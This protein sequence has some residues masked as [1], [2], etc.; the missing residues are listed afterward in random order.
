MVYVDLPLNTNLKPGAYL[1]GTIII[2]ST[3]RS[4]IIPSSALVNRDGYN[5]VMRVDTHNIVIQ[6]KI[7][8]ADYHDYNVDY[9][10][11]KA[12]L[13]LNDKIVTTGAG[14]LNDGDLVQIVSGTKKP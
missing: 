5:Y 3:E 9:V 4:M 7:A 8:L 2:D 14:F 11:V 13:N 12:G 1:A 10:V 6:T